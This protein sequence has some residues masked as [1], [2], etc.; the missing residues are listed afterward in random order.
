MSADI[1]KG[2][3]II[4]DGCG[5]MIAVLARDVYAHEQPRPDMF[6]EN[7]G[8]GPWVNHD[9]MSCRKCGED[10]LKNLQRACKGLPLN[11]KI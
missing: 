7:K 2:S 3:E 8:Q 10:W 9:A 4:C 11:L 6:E 5:E 1:L